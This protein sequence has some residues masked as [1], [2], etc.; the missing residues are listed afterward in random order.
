[1]VNKNRGQKKRSRGRPRTVQN[2][3]RTKHR[4]VHFCDSD[5]PLIDS[6]LSRT[7]KTFSSWA[8]ELLL[9][10]CESD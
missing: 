5:I 2:S 3:L 10:N 4:S 8:R 7:G 6:A 1:M 9:A